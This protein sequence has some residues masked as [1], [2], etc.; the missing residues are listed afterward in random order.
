VERELAAGP[1][2][3]MHHGIRKYSKF[4]PYSPFR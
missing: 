3:A 1:V 4:S 2:P